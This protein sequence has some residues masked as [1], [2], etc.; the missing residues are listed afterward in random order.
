MDDDAVSPTLVD[1]CIDTWSSDDAKINPNPNPNPLLGVSQMTDTLDNEESDIEEQ[2]PDKEAILKRQEIES[3]LSPIQE[4]AAS[5]SFDP[6]LEEGLYLVGAGVRKES[7][8]KVYAVAMYSSPEVLVAASSMSLGKSAR[9]FTPSSTMTSFISKM[10]YSVTA[11]KIASAIGESVRPRY[12][13]VSSDIDKSE[14]LNH[15]GSKQ[16]RWS[17]SK[18]YY[19]PLRLYVGRCKC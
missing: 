4:Y 18:G 5:I 11:E 3:K 9:T 1:S 19:L 2:E 7:I 14:S 15:R 16:G 12:N 10:V 13:D 17:S 8:I 6:N